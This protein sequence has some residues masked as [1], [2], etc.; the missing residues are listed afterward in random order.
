MIAVDTIIVGECMCA[1]PKYFY[2]YIDVMKRTCF[3]FLVFIFLSAGSLSAQSVA[4]RTNMLH[5]ATTTPN[6]GLEFALGKKISFATS[7]GYNPFE[8]NGKH[9]PDGRRINAKIKHWMVSPELKYWFCST[10]QG[11]Y[12]GTGALHSEYNNW[13]DFLHQGCWS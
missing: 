2:F 12:L 3:L 5:L 1:C 6:L 11:W 4:M 9:T 10:Y 7:V 13:R 8:F